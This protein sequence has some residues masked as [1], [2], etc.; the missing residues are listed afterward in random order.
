MKKPTVLIAGTL[1]V[2]LGLP[3]AVIFGFFIAGSLA[4]QH[5]TGGTTGACDVGT[6]LTPIGNL[7]GS[8]AGY[9]GEQL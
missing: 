2:V 4:L 7:P 5:G 1:A 9:S 3:V 8:V 6:S